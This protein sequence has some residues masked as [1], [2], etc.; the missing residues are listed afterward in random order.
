MQSIE[1]NEE[2]K[3]F[4]INKD[5]EYEF[6]AGAFVSPIHSETELRF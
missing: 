2:A 1:S 4:D 5:K 3:E 6:K